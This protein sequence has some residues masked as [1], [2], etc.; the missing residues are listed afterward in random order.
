MH[1]KIKHP[2]S[3]VLKESTFWVFPQLKSTQ[4]HAS[5]DSIFRDMQR[6]KFGSFSSRNV[7]IFIVKAHLEAKTFQTSYLTL[8]NARYPRA[9]RYD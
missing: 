8:I 5:A 7:Q 6:R 3:Q 9:L 1:T 4:S 2:E